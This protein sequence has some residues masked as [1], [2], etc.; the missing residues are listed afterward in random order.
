MF[1]ISW[2]AKRIVKS[3]ELATR[4][5]GTGHRQTHRSP[6]R[7][8]C[9]PSG[10]VCGR[11]GGTHRVTPVC[12]QIGHQT[13]SPSKHA[14]RVS[15]PRVTGNACGRAL[16]SPPVVVASPSPM[17]ARFHSMR[18]PFLQIETGGE[19]SDRPARECEESRCLCPASRGTPGGGKGRPR[20]PERRRFPPLI[21]L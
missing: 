3:R 9:R 17:K 2:A 11:N 18:R 13:G 12:R 20:R 19:C 8:A 10:P 16:T 14:C 4:R 21:R 5:G 1:T 6:S 15:L 7:L